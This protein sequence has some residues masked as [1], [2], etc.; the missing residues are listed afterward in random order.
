M[1]VKKIYL[2]LI[3]FAILTSFSFIAS[4]CS[5]SE[6]YKEIKVVANDMLITENSNTINIPADANFS[7]NDNIKVYGVLPDDSEEVLDIEKKEYSISVSPE[8][9]TPLTSGNYTITVTYKEIKTEIKLVVR[10]S[11]DTINV[12]NSLSKTYDGT[13]VSD[14]VY[15]TKSGYAE[16]VPEWYDV[17]SERT[18]LNDKPINAG[19]YICVLKTPTNNQYTGTTKEVEFT[20]DKADCTPT[21]HPSFSATYSKTATLGTSFALNEHFTWLNANDIPTCNNSEYYAIYNLDSTNYNDC[22]ITITINISP[23]LVGKPTCENE[24]Y[25]YNGNAQTYALTQNE[26]YTIS[27]AEQTTAGTYD[28]TVSLKDKVNYIWAGIEESNADLHFDFIIKKATP[29]SEQLALTYSV[30]EGDDVSVIT[31]PNRYAWAGDDFDFSETTVDTSG[32]NTP[33]TCRATYTPQDTTNYSEVDVNVTITVKRLL[34]IP[35]VRQENGTDKRWIYT[36][37]SITMQFTNQ[38]NNL[39]TYSGTTATDVGE[40]TAT[41]AIK[42]TDFCEWSDNTTEN[43]TVTWYIDAKEITLVAKNSGNYS[44]ENLTTEYDGNYYASFGLLTNLSTSIPFE[45]TSGGNTIEYNSEI[46]NFTVESNTEHRAENGL[47][48]LYKENTLQTLN[49]NVGY[50]FVAVKFKLNSSNYILNSD[51]TCELVFEVSVIPQKLIVEGSVQINDSNYANTLGSIEL[52]T[53]AVAVYVNIADNPSSTTLAKTTISGAWAWQ[54]GADKIVYPQDKVHAIFTS[55]DISGNFENTIVVEIVLNIR[56]TDTIKT[57]IQNTTN[58]GDKIEIEKVSGSNDDFYYEVNDFWNFYAISFDLPYGCNYQY[59]LT[60]ENNNAVNINETI[61]KENFIRLPAGYYTTLYKTETFNIELKVTKGPLINLTKH[62]TI[63]FKQNLT[64][65]TINGNQWDGSSSVKFGDVIAVKTTENDMFNNVIIA[66]EARENNT[67]T[68]ALTDYQKSSNISINYLKDGTNVFGYYLNIDFTPAFD[69]VKINDTKYEITEMHQNIDYQLAL[70]ETSLSLDFLNAKA[71]DLVITYSLNNNTQVTLPAGTYSITDLAINQASITL[72]I[73][74]SQNHQNVLYLTISLIKYTRITGINYYIA[75]SDDAITS[76]SNAITLNS[77]LTRIEPKTLEGFKAIVCEYGTETPASLNEYTSSILQYTI[78]IYDNANNLI[79]KSDI[80]ITLAIAINITPEDGSYETQTLT[81]TEY[82]LTAFARSLA[83]LQVRLANDS[84][85]V[86][87][88][89]TDSSY[90]T[91]RLNNTIEVLDST[92][93]YFFKINYENVCLKL[94]VDLL[95]TTNKDLPDIFKQTSFKVTNSFDS[96]NVVLSSSSITKITIPANWHIE[97]FMNALNAKLAENLIDTSYSVFASKESSSSKIFIDVV[98]SGMTFRLYAEIEI[99]GSIDSNATVKEEIRDSLDKIKVGNFATI[100]Y[101][102]L[103]IYVTGVE[104]GDNII[105]NSFNEHAFLELI[106]NKTTITSGI[107]RISFKYAVDSSYTL[108]VTTTDGTII[109]YDLTI[110]G[111]FTPLYCIQIGSNTYYVYYDENGKICK[112]NNLLDFTEPTNTAENLYFS[113]TINASDIENFNSLS[114]IIAK[115][116]TSLS[117]IKI[118][119][120]SGNLLTGEQTYTIT[121]KTSSTKAYITMYLSVGDGDN[122]VIPMYLYFAE[123]DYDIVFT[124]ETSGNTYNIYYSKNSNDWKTSDNVLLF[125]ADETDTNPTYFAVINST[126]IKD[127]ATISQLD[128]TCIV[129][130]GY[131]SLCDESG[132]LL[133]GEQTYTITPKGEIPFAHITLYITYPLSDKNVIASIVVCFHAGE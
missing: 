133:T 18:K 20:I 66:N 17:T 125:N 105:F 81:T 34:D 75:G 27:N 127:Y 59:T 120:A 116:S 92:T 39:M 58:N 82:T 24:D 45:I 47:L 49:I 115:F 113:A 32:N 104:S 2:Y 94:P 68:V 126:D 64:S 11:D 98:E 54:E 62:V 43:K 41:I 88:V 128:V 16:I 7:L 79:E 53:S 46:F 3:T 30:V 57:Y 103:T 89:Y 111:T 124:L 35:Q 86:L 44:R 109:N 112:S 56:I 101:D 114:A 99:T 4:A 69:S 87:E 70:G 65:I 37:A 117:Q 123:E 118:C 122:M 1:K 95:I 10:N 23:A 14:P 91:K 26:L 83:E 40:H 48:K 119:D 19:S 129:G 12:A 74:T 51:N 29:N 21:A 31:L 106:R 60:A 72:T 97:D 22:L 84:L 8:L 15:T 42:N 50:A 67:Y 108:R 80:T 78:N 77:L 6:K 107:G 38:N 130:D 28:V 33:M 102:D 25:T 55:S 52:I 36:G 13:P 85:L 76:T 63:V 73:F 71:N 9:P 132:N 93:H 61:T 110:N 90:S 131:G 121:P 5:C 96:V 100:N